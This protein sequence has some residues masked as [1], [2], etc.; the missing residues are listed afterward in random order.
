MSWIRKTQ[1]LIAIALTAAPLAAAQKKPAD[2]DKLVDRITAREHQEVVLIREYRPIV[3]TYVQDVREDKDLGWVPVKD[4]YFLGIADLAKGSVEESMAEKKKRI[5]KSV[6]VGLLT[7]QFSARYNPAGFLE[8]IFVDP[9]GFNRRHYIFEYVRRE[10]LGNVRCLVFDVYPAPNSGNGR[11]KGRIWVE[12]HEDT[13]VRFNGVFEPTVEKYGFNLHFDSWRLN[14]GNG[15]W[16]PAYIY[17]GEVKVS[18]SLGGHVRER[19][20]TRLWSYEPRKASLEQEFSEM[21][22]E[23]PDVVEQPVAGHDRSPLEQQHEWEDQAAGRMLDRLQQAGLLA[24]PGSVEKVL[25]TVV[26]N[27]VVTN[28]MEDAPEIQCRVL[29]IS[30]LDIF[31][32]GRTVVFS[33]GLLDVLPDEASLGYILAHEIA[34]IVAGD[35]SV[36]A[37]A[38]ADQT[39]FPDVEGLRK[40]SVRIED[41]SEQAANAK[42]FELFKNSPYKDKVASP[43]LFLKQLES[44][45]KQLPTLLGPH[46]SNS[47]FL[48]S[49]IVDLSPP[50]DPHRVDQIA[51]LPLGS[52]VRL[53]PW[54]NQVEMIRTKPPVITSPREKRPLGLT[55]FFPSLTRAATTDSLRADR[56]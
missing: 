10:F 48:A 16:L 52:R 55:P 42:A 22:V 15:L 12:D 9:N 54:N 43:G 45:S 53:D 41:A 21:T 46:L 39:I 30:S 23:S 11:F 5:G 36:N 56:Q 17:N 31:A 29:L 38:F 26:N 28:N 27:I 32:I 6:P 20:Q 35:S 13:I 49:Q 47:S 34:H 7:D 19:S 51:A 8:M 44:E 1:W 25:N 3:E 40:F 18:N 14:A 4:H 2:I 33:R 50:L 37:F 24:P